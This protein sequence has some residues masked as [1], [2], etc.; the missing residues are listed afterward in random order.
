MRQHKDVRINGKT[1]KK[2]RLVM[3]EHLGTKLNEEEVIHHINGD[4]MDNRLEN[5]EIMNKSDH[6]SLHMLGNKRAATLNR[7]QVK[8]IK[9]LIQKG[10]LNSEICKGFGVTPQAISKIRCGNNWKDVQI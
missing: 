7:E 1:F 10:H 3:E 5:L 8:E 6:D 9:K 2:H 4:A